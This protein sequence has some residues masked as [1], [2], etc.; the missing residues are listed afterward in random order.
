MTYTQCP[1]FQYY[2]AT[3]PT[4]NCNCMQKLTISNTMLSHTLAVI[5]SA[6]FDTAA[7]AILWGNCSCAC[8]GAAWPI[9]TIRSSVDSGSFSPGSVV[10]IVVAV[11]DVVDVV[12]VVAVVDVV[13]V[14]AV[15]AV[16]DV[17]DVVAVV[18][19]VDVV[20][21]VGVVEVVDGGEV[22]VGGTGNWRMHPT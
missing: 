9:G 19:V 1:S 18:D 10:G 8:W 4:G 6:K 3:F 7:S 12:D 20:D 21:V 17:V 22:V 15:V 14:V 11:V 16:V 13:D 5:G 2:V